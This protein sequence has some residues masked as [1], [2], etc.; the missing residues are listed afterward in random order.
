MLWGS[1]DITLHCIRPL[2]SLSCVC[3]WSNLPRNPRVPCVCYSLAP[4]C[5]IPP[6]LPKAHLFMISSLAR[7]V[8]LVTSIPPDCSTAIT[9]GSCGTTARQVRRADEKAPLG[10]DIMATTPG[11]HSPQWLLL[12][13]QLSCTRPRSERIEARPPIHR[14]PFPFHPRG[15]RP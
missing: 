3:A 4:K 8:S 13:L 1:E 11:L 14:V 15:R 5:L 7:S 9:L 2:H 6:P 10:S 12:F